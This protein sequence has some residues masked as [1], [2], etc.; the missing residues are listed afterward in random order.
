MPQVRSG[1]TVV[2]CACFPLPTSFFS[3]S[4][5]SFGVLSSRACACR[6]VTGGRDSTLAVW[7]TIDLGNVCR[8]EWFPSFLSFFSWHETAGEQKPTHL[9]Y[10]TSNS[11]LCCDVAVPHSNRIA[12]GSWDGKATVYKVIH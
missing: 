2:R 9:Q 11:I 6:L 8:V 1:W 7:D 3:L 10:Q 4:L 12:T 5:P